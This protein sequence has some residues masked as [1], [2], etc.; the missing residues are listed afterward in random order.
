LFMIEANFPFPPQLIRNHLQERLL[1]FPRNCIW[2]SLPF[3]SLVYEFAKLIS[4]NV[5]LS[6]KGLL[7]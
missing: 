4:Y 1:G 2:I 7:K 6:I 3:W 5:F